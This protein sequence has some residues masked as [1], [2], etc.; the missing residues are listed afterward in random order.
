MSMRGLTARLGWLLAC[1]LAEPL[2]LIAN[3]SAKQSVVSSTINISAIV[4]PG[5]YVIVNQEM[6]IQQ[7]L[8]NTPEDVL[9]DVFLDNFNGQR[10]KFDGLIA[11]Q[12]YQLQSRLSFS[13][14]GVV[15]QISKPSLINRVSK[16]LSVVQKLSI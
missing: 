13:Q 14:T 16:I 4:T 9:P 11:S 6:T 10:L 3:V 1:L 7:I 8:S 2:L 5:R 12:F 15:Y